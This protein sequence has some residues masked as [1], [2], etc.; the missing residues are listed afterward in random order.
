MKGTRLE[1]TTNL[2][3]QGVPLKQFVPPRELARDIVFLSSPLA[4]TVTGQAIAV[5]GDAQMLV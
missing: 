5:D 1:E 3:F 2:A 4:S